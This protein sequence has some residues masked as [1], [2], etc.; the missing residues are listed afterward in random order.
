MP[1][2]PEPCIEPTHQRLRA[3]RAGRPIVDTCL[4]HLYFPNTGHYFPNTGH[5]R[6]AVQP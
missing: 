6:W 4:A 1:E 5:P 2:R 3:W